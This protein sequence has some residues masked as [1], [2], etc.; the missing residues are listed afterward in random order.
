MA[1]VIGEP[2]SRTSKVVV[3][4]HCGGEMTE[5]E[6]TRFAQ[7][8]VAAWNSRDL[9]RIL[10]HYADDVE[11]TS[12]LVPKILGSDQLSV[13]GKANL[14]AYFRRGLDAYPDLKFTLW[15]AY[16]GV[17]SVIVH[18]ESVR[19]MSSAE[20]MRIRSDGRV[21]EVLAHYA[22]PASSVAPAR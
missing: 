2:A 4:G 11:L 17:Q 5:S 13:R 8:W 15:G 12:P 1:A 10:S 6:A 18:Y 22:A 16:A 14:R 3:S 19:G 20:L 9:E 21:S 7:E